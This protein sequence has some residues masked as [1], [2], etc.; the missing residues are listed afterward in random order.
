MLNGKLEE[1][2]SSMWDLGYYNKL[3][4]VLV[5]RDGHL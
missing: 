5:L 4:L 2:D 3:N 1:Q